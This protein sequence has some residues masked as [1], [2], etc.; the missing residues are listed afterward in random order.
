MFTTPRWHSTAECDDKYDDDKNIQFHP[1]L[2][3]HKYIDNKLIYKET[4]ND[5]DNIQ[6]DNLSDLVD[7]LT[8][9]TNQQEQYCQQYQAKINKLNKE[10]QELQKEIDSMGLKNITDKLSKAEP[11]SEPTITCKICMDNQSNMVLVPC[12]HVMCSGCI[13]RLSKEHMKQCPMCNAEILK[14]MDIYL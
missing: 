11:S 14:C 8:R 10:L 3:N 12:G 1:N 5:T 4:K 6:Q 13:N 7:K 9:W 2:I